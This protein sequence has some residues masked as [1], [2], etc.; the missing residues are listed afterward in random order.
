MA[1]DTGLVRFVYGEYSVSDRDGD[2]GFERHVYEK[3]GPL[4]WH[5]YGSRHIAGSAGGLCS[6]LLEFREPISDV[7]ASTI[8]CLG[9][10]SWMCEV[11]L[12][13]A[14]VDSHS[15]VTSRQAAV[16]RNSK[17]RSADRFG[18]PF[19]AFELAQ[20]EALSVSATG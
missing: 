19:F 4:V 13:G 14:V 2:S 12:P 16:M 10:P 7:D 9:L 3:F 20:D 6:L 18:E 15:W 1:G 8:A 5:V 17:G 11:Q